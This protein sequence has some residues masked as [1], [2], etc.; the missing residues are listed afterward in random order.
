MQG[1]WLLAGS[2]LAR[3]ALG[4]MATTRQWFLSAGVHKV[5]ADVG[6]VLQ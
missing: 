6:P 2:L 3:V 1:P 5:E 4:W